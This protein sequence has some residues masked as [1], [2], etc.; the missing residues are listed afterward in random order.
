M[1]H[2]DARA[3]FRGDPHV[4]RVQ[5]RGAAADARIQRGGVDRFLRE[6]RQV[7]RP[8][9]DAGV[10]RVAGERGIGKGRVV[11]PGH[12]DFGAGNART[13]EGF[14]ERRVRM[15]DATG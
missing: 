3:H 7:E 12:R 6:E 8:D 2:G 14:E 1:D 9:R 13:G 11:A 5:F 4:V 10:A 15:R